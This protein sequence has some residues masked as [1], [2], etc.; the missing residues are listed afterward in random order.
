[1]TDTV[2]RA[3]IP[4]LAEPD[5]ADLARPSEGYLF[6]V[7][8]GRSGS[9]VTQNLLNAIPGY[10]I[11]GENA[12][13]IYPLCKMIDTL[14]RNR[15]ITTHRAQRAGLVKRAK[16]LGTPADPWFGA[17]DIDIDRLARG[18]FNVFAREVLRIPPGTRVAGFKEIRYLQDV[19]FVPRQL[20]IMQHHFPRARI[21]FLTRDHAQVAASAWFSRQ[22]PDNFLPQLAHA[23]AA[24]T[25]YA[26]S[27]PG[28]FHLDYA[29]LI[30]GPQ[31]LRP[32]L[33]FL[34][35]EMHEDKI[36]EV[37]GQRLTHGKPKAARKD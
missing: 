19:T 20:E 25:A 10:C 33:D 13:A 14:E 16:L 6:L 5:F 31:A 2:A 37:L 21:L 9:T 26:A 18:M 29:T 35:E 27:H 34:G 1:M 3:P 17:E 24:F 15:E 11:R 32:L 36:A 23:D 12:N 4:G 8:Y 22:P 7:T 28:C 30:Q